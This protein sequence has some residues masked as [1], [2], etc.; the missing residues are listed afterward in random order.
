[1]AHRQIRESEEPTLFITV[2]NLLDRIRATYGPGG[3]GSEQEVIETV[4]TVEFLVLDDLGAERVTDWVAEKL[5]TIINHRHD[6]DLET[7]FTSNLS[8]EQLAD[9][10]GE[11]TTWRIVEMAD[12]VELSG[13][14]LR[15]RP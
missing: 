14:N 15:D 1:M 12:V 10:I 9:H 5:F 11:R 2:P 7:V 8:L 13:P 3:N 4:K 6:E